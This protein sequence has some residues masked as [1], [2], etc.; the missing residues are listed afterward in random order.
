MTQPTIAHATP[1]A[2][3]TLDRARRPRVFAA[4]WRRVF[5]FA[6]LVFGLPAAAQ[7]GY[8][9]PAWGAGGRLLYDVS[10][11]T[12]DE[13]SALLV[14]PDG[15]LLLL[16]NCN[17]GGASAKVLCAARVQRS[18]ILDPT[19]G[20]SALGTAVYGA[21]P[22]ADW[23]GQLLASRHV[24][25]AGG[26]PAR[27][28]RLTPNGLLDTTLGGLGYR[29]IDVYVPGSTDP[30]NS[31]ISALA[32]QPDGKVLVA[33][34][35]VVA[36]AQQFVVARFLPNLSA[37]DATFGGAPGVSPPGVAL[38]DI[39]PTGVVH[40]ERVTALAVQPDGGIVLAGQA[41]TASN[42]GARTRIVVARLLA[43]GA[44]DAGFD[45]DGRYVLLAPATADEMLAD[46]ALDAQGRIVLAGSM[47]SNGTDFFLAR[48]LPN[49]SN[50]AGFGFF[51][52]LAIAFDRGSGNNDQAYTL[53]LQPDGRI[54]VAGFA[55]VAVHETIHGEAHF[56]VARLLD[57]GALDPAFGIAG[58]GV[59][60]FASSPTPVDAHV[61]RDIAIANGG[62]M[63]AG[64]GAVG[65]NPQDVRFGLAKLRLRT[66]SMFADGFEP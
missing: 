1:S 34:Y 16:G 32:V 36:G 53:A 10:T 59:G 40:G 15:K 8:F 24:V 50:D 5:F 25:V 2:C 47:T 56:A 13:A 27:I 35:A 48:L 57:G 49:G 54:L 11:G 51:G 66:E 22:G 3:P 63:V 39:D 55:N 18:G 61:A 62:L 14:Y 31:A 64:H 4:R 52:V 9:D 45:G 65:L 37:L 19:F 17:P 43:N 46:V 20:P 41:S 38:V 21:L 29:D 33:G 44:L 12:R 23:R 60:A 42:A 7:E 6:A 58:K 28:V 26:T 30:R